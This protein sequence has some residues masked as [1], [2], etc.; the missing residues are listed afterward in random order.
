MAD[1][2]REQL[3]DE[4]VSIEMRMFLAIETPDSMP[5][6]CQEQPNVLKLMRKTSHWVLSVNT[7]KSYLNDLHEAINDN[8]NLMT[9][10]YA[11]MDN[12]IPVLNTNPLIDKIIDI[13]SHWF[14]ELA[15]KYPMTFK[16]HSEYSANIYLRCELET[17]SDTTLELYYKDVSLAA[18]K[19]RNLIADRYTFMFQQ[20]GYDSI[21]EV[22]QDM[23]KN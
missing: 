18:K 20:S 15:A 11:R 19:G 1:K 8:R 22:E 5:S 4:I 7:L 23:K 3:I 21:E 10:K 16:K 17:Y 6:T 13:E 9:L 12:L 14:K 2:T